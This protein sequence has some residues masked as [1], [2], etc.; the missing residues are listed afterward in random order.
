MHARLI[1]LRAQ[2]VKAVGNAEFNG[3]NMIKAAGNTVKSLANADASSVITVAAQTLTT[4]ALSTIVPCTIHS[5]N[6][7][8]ISR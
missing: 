3:S 8:I 6:P 5:E 4:T 7:A 2:I 1:R